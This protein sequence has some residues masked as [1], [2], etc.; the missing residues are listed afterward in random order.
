N[1]PPV[2]F[3]FLVMDYLADGSLADWLEEWTV[4][5]PRDAAKLV[6]QAALGIEAVHAKSLL[7]RDVKPGNLLVNRAA[8][9]V[10]VSDFGLVRVPEKEGGGFPAGERAGSPAY[11]SPEQ[12]EHPDTIDFRADVYGL[13]AVL[14]EC[15]TGSVPFPTEQAEKKFTDEA[16][17]SPRK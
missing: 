3:P 6:Q 7:H 15:L 8:A 9:H 12:T 10:K 17:R 4:F 5:D 14:Y 13:G 1:A 16:P 11:M 2:G